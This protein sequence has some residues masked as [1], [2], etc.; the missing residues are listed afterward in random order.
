MGMD[1]SP[2]KTYEWPL[3][4]EKMLNITS[5]QGSTDQNSEIS[6]L[7][8]KMARVKEIDK[9]N[10]TW[11]SRVRRPLSHKVQRLWSHPAPW[12]VGGG[13]WEGIGLL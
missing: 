7:A 8:T 11:S 5:H 1:I 10:Y 4:H 9:S 3:T 2:E 13:S 12:L 6:P